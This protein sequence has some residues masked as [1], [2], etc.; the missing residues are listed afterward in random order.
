MLL[1]GE[2]LA[3]FY[4]K[5]EEK[6]YSL[7]EGLQ[8]R[9]IPVAAYNNFLE[10]RGLPSFPVTIGA[11][12]VIAVLLFT[13]LLIG[14]G[15]SPIATVTVEDHLGNPLSGV[16]V[17]VLDS[18]GNLLKEEQVNAS[19]EI[20]LEGIPM[21]TVLEFKAKKEGY[22]DGTGYGEATGNEVP[23]SLTLRKIFSY[24]DGTL[25]LEDV[26]TKDSITEASVFFEIEFLGEF[27]GILEEGVFVFKGIPAGE[28]GVL[29]INAPN[30]E[31]LQEVVFFEEGALITK[32]LYKKIISLQGKTKLL[33]RVVDSESGELVPGVKI[34]IV[35]T[36]YN[37]I[38]TEAIA[39]DGE[40][41]EELDTGMSIKLL[42]EK[43]QYLT[44]EGVA[45]TLAGE[46]ETIEVELVKGGEVLE[47]ILTDES[48]NLQ[49]DG[50]IQ[51]YREGSTEL[52]DE[53]VTGFA[54]KVDFYGLDPN[55]GYFVTA[56]KA[57]FLPLR[58]KINVAEE[59]TVILKLKQ[60]TPGNSAA[61]DITV[62]D[63]EDNLV[64]NASVQFFEL[65]EEEMLAMGIPT[66]QTD[67]TGFVQQYLPIGKSFLVK[68]AKELEKG[69][70]EVSIASGENELQIILLKPFTV[71]TMNLVDEDGNPFTG[72]A[73]VSSLDERILFSGE[74]EEGELIFDRGEDETVRVK[75]IFEDGN[76]FSAEVN[77]KD[78][79]EMPLTV[80]KGKAQFIPKISF[81]GIFNAENEPVEGM[82]K[83]EY[84]WLQF[85][86]EWIKADYDGGVHIRV[87]EDSVKFVDSQAIGIYGFDATHD[88]FVLG[89]SY[90][91]EPIPGN[92]AIDKQ[93]TGTAGK[94]SKWVELYYDSPENVEL[95]KVKV[96][97]LETMLE[98]KFA[99]KFRAW[100]DI[101][102]EFYRTP[103]DSVLGTDRYNGERNQ[104]YAETINQEIRVFDAR[105]VN[106]S[107]AEGLCLSYEFVNVDE[108]RFSEA[109][110]DPVT[111]R[112]YA[113]E[114][115]LR[116]DEDLKPTLRVSTEKQHPA[117]GL[118]SS[119]VQSFSFPE[120]GA[121]QIEMQLPVIQL[122]TDEEKRARVYFRTDR[123]HTTFLEVKLAAGEKIVEK[124][125]YFNISEE[126][127]MQLSLEPENVLV[128]QAFSVNVKD[129]NT[130]A[131]ITNANLKILDKGNTQVRAAVG[132]NSQGKGRNG[133]YSFAAGLDPGYYLAKVEA[134]G[135]ANSEIP[136]FIAETG[137]LNMPEEIS[138]D[139]PF[140]QKSRSQTAV[141][142]NKSKF[143][144]RNFTYS[145]EKDDNWPE[146]LELSVNVQKEIVAAQ[147]GLITIRTEYK[148]KS[149]ERAHGEG[150][151]IVTGFIEGLFPVQLKSRVKVSYNKPLP[152]ECL[153]LD[154]EE[155][156][157]V[158]TGYGGQAEKVPLTITNECD[159]E[160]NIKPYAEGIKDSQFNVTSPRFVLKAGEEKEIVLN[161]TNRIARMYSAMTPY[162][163]N[164]YLQSPQLTISLPLIVVTRDPSFALQ[165]NNNIH[166]WLKPEEGKQGVS[167]SAPLYV[168]NVGEKPI[169]NLRFMVVG[170]RQNIQMQVLPLNGMYSN[171]PMGSAGYQTMPVQHS[172]ASAYNRPNYVT[173]GNL[174]MGAG[175]MPQGNLMRS[176]NAYSPI[177]QYGRSGYGQLGYGYSR[178]G[179]QQPGYGAMGYP[180]QSGIGMFGETLYPGQQL[181]PP[182]TI[183][184]MTRAGSS[185]SGT[186]RMQVQING[187]INGRTYPLRTV[188]VFVHVTGTE[189]LK[190]TPIDEM[191]FESSKI[192]E[193]TSIEKR[194]KLENKCGEPIRAITLDKKAFGENEMRISASTDTMLAGNSSKELKLQFFKRGSYGPRTTQVSVKGLLVT[195][196][197]FIKSNPIDVTINIGREA[198]TE[199]GP[200]TISEKVQVCG[201]EAEKATAEINFPK[202]EQEDC[203]LGYCDAVTFSKW[204]AKKIEFK[205]NQ[206]RRRG[207]ER[208]YNLSEFPTCKGKP[209]CSFRDMGILAEEITAYLQHDFVSTDILEKEFDKYGDLKSFQ[210]DYKT[211][212]PENFSSSFYANQLFINQNLKGCGKYTLKIEGGMLVSADKLSKEN[213]ALI[214]NVEEVN[215]DLKE[216][217]S[218][219]EN[220]LNF[221]PEDKGLTYAKRYNTW[222]GIVSVDT[223]GLDA[224]EKAELVKRGEDFAIKL[225]ESKDRFK[226]GVTNTNVLEVRFGKIEVEGQTFDGLMK[227]EMDTANVKDQPRT[228][229]ATIN[230]TYLQVA[231]TPTLQKQMI[232]EIADAIKAIAQQKIEGCI[233]EDRKAL[234]IKELPAG[235]G[236]LYVKPETQKLPIWFTKQNCVDFIVES[237]AN[238]T[239]YLKT[240]WKEMESKAGLKEVELKT[241]KGEKIVEYG[242]NGAHK[243]ELTESK[244]RKGV[245]EYKFKLCVK[246]NRENLDLAIGKELKVQAKSPKGKRESEW[247][248]AVIEFCAFTPE[249]LLAELDRINP[250]PGEKKVYYFQTAW[251]GPENEC[252]SLAQIGMARAAQN[253]K[254]I[255]R[256]EGGLSLS[257]QAPV[258]AAMASKKRKATWGYSGACAVISALCNKAWL[259]AGFIM[260]PASVAMDCLPGTLALLSD[261]KGL[262]TAED[263]A[264]GLGKEAPDAHWNAVNTGSSTTQPD[265][266]WEAAKDYMSEAIGVTAIGVAIKSA[267]V[268]PA[269]AAQKVV[270]PKT[271][272][273]IAQ[274]VVERI[275]KLFLA[276][277]FAD[278]MP[279]TTSG[280]ITA[281]GEKDVRKALKEMYEVSIKNA[282]LADKTNIGKRVNKEMIEAAIT[283]ASGDITDAQIKKLGKGVIK[284][285]GTASLEDGLHPDLKTAIRSALDVVD[286]EKVRVAFVDDI[287]KA[288]DVE[289]IR[290]STGGLDPD[291]FKKMKLDPTTK[292]PEDIIKAIRPEAERIS[293]DLVDDIVDKAG[294]GTHW[295][296]PQKDSL[297]KALADLIEEKIKKTGTL[298]T[299]EV[300]PGQAAT[301]ASTKIDPLRERALKLSKDEVSDITR[302]AIDKVSKDAR[303]G[304][305]GKGNW[306]L[307]ERT[308]E[309]E[310]KKVKFIKTSGTKSAIEKAKMLQ[311]IDD[312]LKGDGSAQSAIDRSGKTAQT[313]RMRWIE[314]ARAMKTGEFWKQA[315]KDFG[316]GL[317]CAAAANAAGFG[318]YMGVWALQGDSAELPAGTKS[319]NFKAP[320]IVVDTDGDGRGDYVKDGEEKICNKRVYKI[321]ITRKK[322]DGVDEKSYSITKVDSIPVK[323]ELLQ[324]DCTGKGVKTE[325]SPVCKIVV[326]NND[327]S[328]P[329]YVKYCK[330]I[331]KAFNKA[332]ASYSTLHVNEAFLVALSE[333]H[334]GIGFFTEE[335][336]A[337][338]E[339]NMDKDDDK[340]V[341]Y[342]AGCGAVKDGVTGRSSAINNI[343][344]DLECAA[345]AMQELKVLSGNGETLNTE[346]LGKYYDGLN[347]DY[348]HGLI[349]SKEKYVAVVKTQ[350]EK[351]FAYAKAT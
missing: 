175:Y 12:A 293:T 64:N 25:R 101:D 334:S 79:K 220:M 321:T 301:D 139:M 92:E 91:A 316:K 58:R 8:A 67:E 267:T 308:V 41:V 27:E 272:G 332:E 132:S 118:I 60:A 138:I 314:G 335:N 283:K 188:A 47:V 173:P 73:V 255:V 143:T 197:K 13:F 213:I 245:Y 163:F 210:I 178:Y 329:S 295:S 121:S 307:G 185:V 82:E 45:R 133:R 33:I 115:M 130:G 326:P 2:R 214:I 299:V 219:I 38:L 216:C 109:E 327:K 85:K 111:N 309:I 150:D 310:G 323:A 296:G 346:E 158:L 88:E 343:D 156:Q 263:V 75:A 208:S 275:Q 106:E 6:W 288:A 140:N 83:E 243:K 26:D 294:T 218:E 135:Y 246:G 176:H 252:V 148:G 280:K 344:A 284:A 43:E 282:L 304:N 305:T 277:T 5:L 328:F 39:D 86:T 204:I 237:K 46:E 250:A 345:R 24:I 1:F 259:G 36:E 69:E 110:F 303:F 242:E 274:T 127:V 61:L 339:I 254:T 93:N 95:V 68:A 165:T 231:S 152:E 49:S 199:E 247:S 230:D 261:A 180:M 271:A 174:P 187:M 81:V 177:D 289:A 297:K 51:L 102:N 286:P 28:E 72:S 116:S 287:F 342:F 29:K 182:K 249:M 205:I 7:L 59:E 260:A 318:G 123:P 129:T 195:S 19:G 48:G 151:L 50:T 96:K 142:E 331:S 341:D 114:L 236:K 258:K 203:S 167:G 264:E 251:D 20:S 31:E 15:L 336:E 273:T 134:K 266:S 21:G 57:G 257:N 16:T 190:V 126:G 117:L 298:E 206:V 317:V 98:K 87:G 337:E 9:G 292:I 54:G 56:Y 233:T 108:E 89:R 71:M 285:V 42:V 147:Q 170:G 30:Y 281:V 196:Q 14:Q 340:V 3:G 350:Y 23:V 235:L 201:K 268:V 184:A 172:L 241:M 144:V 131:G 84:Y 161:V 103:V 269:T 160:L 74:V 99:V 207:H 37:S 290:L 240:N 189:C 191:V 319:E 22:E 128:G 224:A 186:Q 63:E 137:L 52:S 322:K 53:K 348:K 217:V 256:T 227:L 225:F 66:K 100:A 315:A 279:G 291:D 55:Q 229:Y 18:E 302:K 192:V 333:V 212:K 90:S 171:N 202:L 198:A 78:K 248:K 320:K 97:A 120:R 311:A 278:P 149:D 153:S 223:K 146:D 162:R 168:M 104:L 154:K 76:S 70:K 159:E 164:F 351:W 136:V 119:Q 234:I 44:Y 239:V 80:Y 338:D 10:D 4:G 107:C 179:L 141:I 166:I 276:E 232:D 312:V 62:V 194:V 238:E 265:S 325:L 124:K 32:P 157:V 228:I 222:A 193:G 155:I 324:G 35:D 145:F 306:P 253:P 347:D 221:L 113:L 349:D 215:N 211:V 300:S 169:Q 122:K 330:K 40:R 313:R 270:G 226:E 244:E 183:F 209:F 11:I 262:I 125:I 112:I 17:Q 65:I 105:P 77:V 181:V 34:K 200:V 94:S